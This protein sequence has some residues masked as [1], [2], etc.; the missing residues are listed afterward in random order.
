MI[1]GLPR[2]LLSLM[3]TKNKDKPQT[4]SIAVSKLLLT[5]GVTAPRRLIFERS[6]GLVL[7][8]QIT[9]YRKKSIY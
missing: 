2:C 1:N 4:I 8:A 7:R 6:A 5:I 3:I 9:I